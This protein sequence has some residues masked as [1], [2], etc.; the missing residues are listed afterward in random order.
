MNMGT[1][2]IWRFLDNFFQDKSFPYS[3]ALD[4]VSF[5]VYVHF[6]Y[7]VCRIWCII[8]YI[9]CYMYCNVICKVLHGFNNGKVGNAFVVIGIGEG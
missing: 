9:K 6:S 3:Q 8:P 2:C 4:N 1:F 5:F 7:Y